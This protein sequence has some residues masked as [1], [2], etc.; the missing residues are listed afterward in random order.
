MSSVRVLPLI[1]EVRDHLAW[2]ASRR[3]AWGVTAL[4]AASLVVPFVLFAE[5]PKLYLPKA[6]ALVL[7][8]LCV[9]IVIRA[10]DWVERKI[11]ASFIY[12]LRKFFGIIL[13]A[14][15]VRLFTANFM[16]LIHNL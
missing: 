8:M 14:I 15:S 7:N 2:Q 13:L 3:I 4:L 11:S 12:L 10:T 5:Q 16:S 9:Y 1:V 6:R